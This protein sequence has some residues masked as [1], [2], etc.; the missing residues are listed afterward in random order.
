MSETAEVT[1]I[2]Q[3]KAIQKYEFTV[4]S[5]TKKVNEYATIK[6]VPG[7]TPSYKVARKALTTCVS[8]R[9]GIDKRRK[10]LNA[11]YH[12]RIADN[13]AAGK[14]L[15]TAIS[16][17]EQHLRVEV[18]TEDD[19]KAAIKAEK[20]RLEVERVDGIQALIHNIRSMVTSL[21]GMDST[22]LTTLR[23][24]IGSITLPPDEYM[25]FM[26][27]ANQA[28]QDAHNAAKSALD[29][30]LVWEAEEAA[31]K[32]ETERLEKVRKE[33]EIEAERLRKIQEEQDAKRA[34]EDARLFAERAAIQAEKDKLEAEKKAE[35]ERK[36]LEA[37][38]EKVKT[39]A[40]RAAKEKVERE[41]RERL[42]K[43]TAEAEEKERLE[44]LKPDKEKLLAYAD[45]LLDVGLPVLESKNAEDVLHVAHLAVSELT[46][47]LRDSVEGL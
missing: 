20:E 30:R 47:I 21:N 13:N 39:E 18:D 19:R 23:D 35:Q 27:E 40:E 32:L 36:D 38:R 42:A 9:T 14:I 34:E 11:D 37:M 41:E 24:E 22:A 45:E 2:Q 6:I 4:E 10:E 12:A 25:E 31:R 44:A 46:N 5:L 16:P 43:E 26:A 8:M 15:T 33:Q 17:A 3:N 1:D 28:V 7:D 29:D